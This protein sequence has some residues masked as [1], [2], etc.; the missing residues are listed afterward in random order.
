MLIS[1]EKPLVPK[2]PLQPTKQIENL[3]PSTL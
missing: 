1:P 3:L 2:H